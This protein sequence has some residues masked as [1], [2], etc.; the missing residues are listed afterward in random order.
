MAGGWNFA[1]TPSTGGLTG[2]TLTLVEGESF[3]ISDAGGDIVPGT[4]QGLF[5]RDTRFLSGWRLLVDD[6]PPEHLAVLPGTPFA[7]AVLGLGR[8]VG[9][10]T[11]STLLVFRHRYVGRGMRED[12]VL[13]NAALEPAAATLTLHVDADFAHLFEVKEERVVPRGERTVTT[14]G[15]LSPN[16]R[17][18]RRWDTSSSPEQPTRS[19]ISRRVGHRTGWPAAVVSA[20]MESDSA[21]VRT[22]TSA[23]TTVPPGATT[24]A[25]S[26]MAASGS[27]YQWKDSVHTTASTDDDRTGR[28][29]ASPWTRAPTP[30]PAACLSM[31]IDRSQ[32]KTAAVSRWWLRRQVRMPVPQPTSSTR[33][34]PDRS[35]S[36]T[37]AS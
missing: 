3:C 30:R 11:D 28:R 21:R 13:R 16:S 4:A 14:V 35:S 5:D 34:D 18:T 17:R 33:R 6:V 36:P 26:A 23:T 7:A 12:L 25:N 29:C 37:T 2:P 9:G 1:G 19:A 27:G 32:P 22:L 8:P 24:R 20:W 10:R 15:R 31:P